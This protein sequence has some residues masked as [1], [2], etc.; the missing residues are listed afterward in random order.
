MQQQLKLKNK[1]DD[2]EFYQHF[3]RIWH[4]LRAPFIVTPSTV[5]IRIEANISN[6][7]VIERMLHAMQNYDKE[8]FPK[9]AT[10]TEA[11]LYI[12][13]CTWERPPS[14]EITDI[15][16]YLFARFAKSQGIGDID[17]IIGDRRIDKLDGFDLHRL[18]MLKQWIYMVQE[19]HLKEISKKTIR[20][21]HEKQTQKA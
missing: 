12:L 18:K 3:E 21:L 15:A 8:P 2:R 1:L 20:V 5:D 14:S 4:S 7:I 11:L 19:K 10:D 17:H 6:Q 13:R 9:E 16:I